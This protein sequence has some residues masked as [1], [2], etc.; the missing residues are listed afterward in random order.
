MQQISVCIVPL[1]L[2]GQC[3]FLAEQDQQGMEEALADRTTMEQDIDRLARPLPHQRAAHDA[4]AL[5][6]KLTDSI[7]VACSLCVLNLVWICCK[8]SEAVISCSV[9]VCMVKPANLDGV[10]CWAYL[11]GGSENELI[12]MRSS[13]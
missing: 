1:V 13:M 7:T 3:T 2:V 5:Q 6:S 10:Y 12:T 9:E 4:A 8:Y 11:P